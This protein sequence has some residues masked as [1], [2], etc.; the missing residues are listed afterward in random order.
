MTSRL[1]AG[2]AIAALLLTAGTASAQELSLLVGNS[3]DTVA[4]AEALTA[5]Y[6]ERNPEVT[7]SVE[8]RPGGAEGD[9]VVKTR[10][11]TGEMGDLFQYNSG[12]LLQALRPARTLEPLND[13]DNIGNV[14]DS[15]LPTVS[16]AD[17]NVYGI[18]DQ[19]AMGGGI[20][21]HIPTYEELG[22]E[23]PTTWD[24]FM[25]NNAAIAE[26]TDKAPVIQTYRAT[27]TSQILVLAD[28]YNVEQQA[29]GFAD[30]FT[31]N[32]AKFATTP[33]ALQ[34]FE[35]LQ[36]LNEAGYLNEDYGAATYEDGLEMIARGE[37]VHYP[38]LTFAIGA[39][40]QNYGDLMED[41]GF[42]AQPGESADQ[43]GLTVWMPSAY[44][45]PRDAEHPEI[46]R[47]F[48]NWMATDEACQVIIDAVGAT[49]PYLIEGCDLPDG[50]PTSVSDMM[51]YFEREGGTFPAL[52]FLSPVKGPALEQ[53]TVEVGSGIR[54]AQDAAAIYDEDVRKQA[55]QL[56]LEGW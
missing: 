26:Q 4:I 32:E 35:R 1:K 36:E 25:E 30:R 9:N 55:L 34:G 3:P 7:F 19:S 37:G 14:I 54:S 22:L 48:L 24:Q 47:D 46:A 53:L 23:V 40:Q 45:M 31:A 50:V 18:P 44:F 11:A 56:G 43:N 52:E 42:F 21:Y 51:P 12:S 28:Y 33:A 15:F 39:L 27:W 16:D 6:T 20:L 10:L 5:A 17:G 2:T 29:P 41:I 49:G 38:M 13:L 8:V